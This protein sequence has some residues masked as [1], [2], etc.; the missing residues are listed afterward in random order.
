M[1]WYNTVVLSFGN[2]EWDEE[3]LRPPKSFVPLKKI[4]QWLKK[5]HFEVP[6]SDLGEA[7]DL[8]SNAVLLGGTYDGLDVE[9]FCQFI[10]TLKWSSL[11]NVQIL[12]W[13]DNDSKFKVVSFP[14][15]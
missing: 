4:N 14:L 7:G 10:Q 6:L 9:K 5:H 8:G 2:N 13:G 15:E 11:E 12:F 3:E 1:S